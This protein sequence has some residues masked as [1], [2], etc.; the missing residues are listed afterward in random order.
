MSRVWQDDNDCQQTERVRSDNDRNERQTRSKSL[1]RRSS[2]RQHNETTFVREGN[3]VSQKPA[4]SFVTVLAPPPPSSSSSSLPRSNK[5]LRKDEG[6]KS[7]NQ[8]NNECLDMAAI[9]TRLRRIK[10]RLGIYPKTSNAK[11]PLIVGSGLDSYVVDN[12]NNN[13]NDNNDDNKNGPSQE[14]LLDLRDWALQHLFPVLDDKRLSLTPDTSA[15]VH[16]LKHSILAATQFACRLSDVFDVHHE[17]KRKKTT[18]TTTRP[19]DTSKRFQQAQRD[20]RVEK[21]R[22]MQEETCW[23]FIRT[24]N[25]DNY[26]HHPD[27][28]QQ[29][30]QQQLLQQQPRPDLFC[31]FPCGYGKS[32]IYALP[33]LVDGGITLV[34]QPLKT[35]IRDQVR[36]FRSVPGLHV[37]E[38]YS[39]DDAAT[40]KQKHAS[41]R[42]DELLLLHCEEEQRSTARLLLATPELLSHREK[43]LKALT[44]CGILQRVVVDEFDCIEDT[45]QNFR[46]T[47]QDIVRL[48]RENCSGAQFLFLSATASKTSLLGLL[49]LNATI[50]KTGGVQQPHLYLAKVPLST[51]L[52]FRVE[53][54]PRSTPTLAKRIKEIIKQYTTRMKRNRGSAFPPPKCLC[55]C[56]QVSKCKEMSDCLKALGY[57]AEAVS[58]R[59]NNDFSDIVRRFETGETTILCATSGKQNELCC[60][61]TF[62][63]LG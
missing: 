40:L 16:A 33:T 48:L 56:L 30:Q 61:C 54:K 41:E 53:R 8:N 49:N 60:C 43:Q 34:V 27:D 63:F 18:T 35:L 59:D 1:G 37:E 62:F 44:A 51:S 12:D 29:Q 23:G 31:V 55:Y 3:V 15:A 7:N 47:Y 13:D 20:L 2:K 52:S 38:L 39:R 5:R 26:Q 57:S 17:P 9:K 32:L 11:T 46:E 14:Q 58:S 6:N 19:L 45:G 36:H 24:T 50:S 28:D 42:L 22:P 25:N 10:T 21:L 4:A